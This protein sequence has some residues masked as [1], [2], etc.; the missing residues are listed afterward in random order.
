VAEP[1]TAST[2]PKSRLIAFYVVLFA[3]VAIVAAIVISAGNDEK[4]LESIA[5][6]YD[7]SAPNPCLGTPPAPAKGRPLPPTA[8]AQAQ[9]AGPSFDVKQSGQ[10]VNLSNS[11]KT[12]SG[13]LR[14][15]G[16]ELPGGARKLSGDVNCV[17]GAKPETQK[18]EGRATTGD[19]AT[20]VGTLD[21]KPV[22]AALK[23][24]PPDAGTP[25]PRAP[26]SIASLYKAT[27]RSACIGGTFEL[28]KKNDKLYELKAK[29]QALGEVSYD[30]KKGTVA[31]DVNCTKG[32]AV[33]LKALAVD[34]NLN[35][36]K[37]IP[38]DPATPAKGQEGKPKPVLTTPSG[39]SPAGENF[40][41]TKQ[42]ESFGHTIASALI[43]IAV[44]MLVA[45]LFGSLA[46]KVKQ[47]RVM[48]EV[49]AGI[50]LGPTILGWLAPG[51]Q[52]TLFPTDILPS[53]GIIA[54][55]G[56]V[57]YMF[58]VGLEI[59][60]AQLR[61]RIGQAA[62]IS[63]TSVALPMMLGIA[64]ALPIYEVVGPEKDFLPFALFMGVAMSI[65]AFPV[66]ARILVE[67]RM[68]KRP[69]GALALACAAID[70]VT[71]WFLIALATAVATQGGAGDVLQT[72]GL[73]VA[74]CIFMFVLV[75]PLLG[76]VSTAFD[77]AGRVPG[78]WIAAI[79][80]GVL[81][82]AYI[83][84]EIG[85][86]VIFGAFIM[87]MIMPRNAG[88]TEDVTNRIEDFVVIV[89][90]PVFFAYTGLR[91]NIG[92]LD[93]PVLWLITGVL[94]VVA[95]VG[96]L[97]GAAIAA[98]L[99]GFDWR[100]SFVIGTLMNTR[101]LT[102]LI[103]L[104]LALEKGVI[105]D[106]LFAALVIMALVTTFMAGPML[107]WLD[108]KNTYGA[109][110]EE[111]LEE[112]RKRSSLEFP[113]TPAPERSIL[114]APQ[115]DTG[116]APLLALAEPLARSE[117]PRE[118]ILSRLVRPP[119]RAQATGGLQTENRRLREASNEVNFARLELV[120][121]GI[122]ARAIAFI[123]ANPGADL[124]RL[125]MSEEVDLLLL[126][127]R[128][129]LLGGGVPRGDVGAVLNDAESDVAVLVAKE[130]QPVV[131][132]PESGVLVPF[133]GAEH[134]WAALELGAWI[135]SA[136][137]APLRLLGAAGQSEEGKS[138]T[139]L[140]G[141]AGLLVQQYAGIPAEPVVAEPGRE[142]IVAAAAGSGLLVI[143][144]S[145]RW[146]QEGLGPTRSE[147]AKAAPAPVIFVRR[148]LR[149]GALAP[150]GDV[151]RFT[152][153][154]PG[155]GFTPGEPIA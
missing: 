15:E 145:D 29:E 128:R 11:Q 84:E 99:T 32:G 25:A 48:G 46:V 35:N 4:G 43:A 101:G 136:T 151:T 23:R 2:A 19:K 109:P 96:K 152:W 5:G 34:R 20:I 146:R 60:P 49:V 44:I 154:S 119:R 75:R 45:R 65:T 53:L 121:K 141:D 68:L 130:G 17:D 150:R 113:D 135:A 72:I 117:P 147:I 9:V 41:A 3:I 77:E 33:K 83:T 30:N 102:E 26:G 56:L 38:L 94:I 131:P 123:S 149:P 52:A 129:P 42:R 18:F 50:T 142:G 6:G 47:P 16:D 63:N 13:K 73:A 7:V 140:L 139:R 93:R 81:L 21:G 58:L 85:I 133:G 24:D 134:D 155:T 137:G 114:V 31:G 120:D 126:D 70:D 40:T 10:F 103:V 91:T 105:T 22:T 90:L 27:P 104:N 98:R 106:A 122:A 88:L 115:T 51:L 110:V 95:V 74:F 76:R 36:V 107:S 108:P 55:V 97:F 89:L 124:S 143:G 127:G 37:L 116:L 132:T 69:V 59:D 62:A 82:S 118:L 8:P 92:L 144:L 67:R 61:G 28:E 71:A 54:N 112:A 125:A 87:G 39:L 57:F 80:A 153:S 111:E 14:F 86:A 66:L 64:V 138:A 78:A 1:A 148:G 100:A 12:L 79:F